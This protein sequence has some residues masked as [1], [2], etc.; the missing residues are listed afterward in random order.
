MLYLDAFFANLNMV[1][2]IADYLSCGVNDVWAD[3]NAEFEQNKFYYITRGSCVIKIGFREYYGKEGTCFFIPAN[4]RH[5][6]RNNKE[7]PFEK[8]WFHFDIYPNAS[9]FKLL[10]LDYSIHTGDNGLLCLFKEL[11]EKYESE[12]LTDKLDIKS[13][14][15]RILSAFIAASHRGTKIIS[16]DPEDRLS[17][18]LSHI[19]QNLDKHLSNTELSELCYLHPNHFVRYFKEKTGFTPQKY[20]MDRRT[21]MA[22]RLIEQT[23][24]N[25]SD[26]A[27]KTGFCDAPHLSKVFKNFYSLTPLEYR[28]LRDK[29]RRTYSDTGFHTE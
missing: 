21:E 8:C 16:P 3:D 25:L 18:V 7:E 11:T 27:A 17:A 12:N 15:I 13:L 6:Y 10:D 20:I 14:A 19:N 5:S 1:V 26:I 28:K 2:R 9:I 24:M 29:H 4:T 23:D 22:K